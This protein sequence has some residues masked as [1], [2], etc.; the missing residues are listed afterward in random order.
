MIRSCVIVIAPEQ[1]AGGG[2][3]A[4]KNATHAQRDDFSVNNRGRTP[5]AGMSGWRTG[6]GYG[7]VFVLPNFL[8]VGRVK[9]HGNFIVSLAA[10]NIEPVADQGR[11]RIAQAH[12]GFPFLGEFLGPSGR[13]GESANL[14]IPIRASPLGPILRKDAGG[15]EQKQ[16]ACNHTDPSI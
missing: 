1:I 5:G 6:Y 10:K 3:E 16:T 13:G 12:C 7:R 8:A 11:R 15:S 14:P 4:G 9:A 2:V